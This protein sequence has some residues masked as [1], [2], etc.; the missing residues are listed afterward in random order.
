VV[1]MVVV[2]MMRVFAAKFEFF[3]SGQEDIW[4]VRGNAGMFS[5]AIFELLVPGEQNFRPVR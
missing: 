1:V 5:L 3:V 2:L 4:L